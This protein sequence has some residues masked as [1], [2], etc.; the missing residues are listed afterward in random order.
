MTDEERQR[1]VAFQ[2]AKLQARRL[3]SEARAAKKAEIVR[4]LATGKSRLLRA[5]R[6]KNSAEI[7]NLFDTLCALRAEDSALRLADLEEHYGK[8]NRTAIEAAARAY[9]RDCFALANAVY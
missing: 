7:N 6:E 1:A 8:L 2:R 3:T 5:L 4:S 9:F